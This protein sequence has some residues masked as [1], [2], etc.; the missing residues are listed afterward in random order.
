MGVRKLELVKQYPYAGELQHRIALR[1]ELYNKIV[2]FDADELLELD[3][4]P[5]KLEE[6]RQ[7]TRLLECSLRLFYANLHEV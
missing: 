2:E 7:R 6:Y 3:I 1:D 4:E 5:R